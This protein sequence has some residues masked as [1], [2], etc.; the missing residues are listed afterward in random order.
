[1]GTADV[2]PV[3]VG[4]WTAA[5]AAAVVY[6]PEAV[7]YLYA[8]TLG[9][10]LSLRFRAW[11]GTPRLWSFTGA[12]YFFHG[13]MLSYL[14]TGLRDSRRV[15]TMCWVYAAWTLAAVPVWRNSLNVR[16]LEQLTATFVHLSPSLVVFTERWRLRRNRPAR[17]SE[18]TSVADAGVGVVVYSFLGLLLHLIISDSGA[19]LRVNFF[20]HFTQRVAPAAKR[21]AD[22]S[23]YH[24]LRL[25]TLY[26]GCMLGYLA[27]SKQLGRALN[28]SPNVHAGAVAVST[29]VAIRNAV[30]GVG[31]ITSSP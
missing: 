14:F 20:D 1:M 15:F 22:R 30:N 24:R 19:P 8:G 28:K 9:L 6:R 12:C 25:F 3:A 13:L 29:A 27:G 17:S 18:D 4:G 31:H 23:T 16:D 2:L 21:L 10:L 5:A 7:R 26:T 11:V